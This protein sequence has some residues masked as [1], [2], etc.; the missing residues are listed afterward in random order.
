MILNK[1]DFPDFCFQAPY[2]QLYVFSALLEE[3]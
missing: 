3:I 1:Q 2:L